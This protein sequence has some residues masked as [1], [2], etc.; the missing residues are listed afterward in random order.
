MSINAVK[1]MAGRMN[2]A[3]NNLKYMVINKKVFKVDSKYLNK[4][5]ELKTK[6]SD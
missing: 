6:Y 1:N 4:F 3:I 5:C 2:L